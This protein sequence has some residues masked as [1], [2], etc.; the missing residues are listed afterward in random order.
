MTYVI[1]LLMKKYLLI[2]VTIFVFI[3]AIFMGT[4]TFSSA[5]N[6]ITISDITKLDLSGERV[7][8]DNT[9][10]RDIKLEYAFKTATKYVVNVYENVGGVFTLVESGIEKSVENG[11][12]YYE[13]G[14][15]GELRIECIALNQLGTSIGEIS[16]VVK[17]DVTPPTAPV[18][19]SDGVMD[20]AHSAPFSVGY[21]VNGDNL[22]GIDYSRSCYSYRDEEGLIVIPETPIA[23]VYSKAMVNGIDRNGTLTFIIYD[24]AGN[25]ISS[26]KEYNLHHYVESTPPTITVTPQTGYSQ[27]VMVTLSWPQGVS[28]RY[29]KLI[30]N[31]NEHPRTIYD[32]PISI[33]D[34]GKVEIRAYYYKDGIE[35]YVS[36]N[37]T[38]VDNTP[39]VEN[40]IL[41]TIR[42]KVDLTSDTPALLSV[43]PH[44]GKSGIKRVYLKGFGTN[45]HTGNNGVGVYSLDV[46]ER[47]GMNVGIVV[48]DNAGNTTD[49]NY[50]LNGYD[51]EKIVYY[52]NEYKKLNSS[53]FES[54][55]WSELLNSFSRLSNVLSSPTSTGGDIST[56]A[57][58]V[59]GVLSGKNEVKVTLIDIIDGLSNDF[60]ASVP[61]LGTS[62]KKG[63]K[64]NLSVNKIGV[65]ED[66]F[67]EKISVGA[68]IAKFPSYKGYGFN[69]NLTDRDG[70]EVTIYNQM[71]VS[72][73][74]PGTNKLANV[75]QEKDGV[76]VQLSSSIENNVLTFQ[77]ESDGNFYLIVETDP[78]KE[79]G[80][81][82]TIGG[83]FYSLN[84]LLITG[85]IILG[86]MVLAGIITPLIYKL[87]KNKK[88]SRNKFDYFN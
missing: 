17:S 88:S 6:E 45:F 56:Y 68:A 39:P 43:K 86:A 49:Y 15:N 69:L 71:S 40:S 28:N 51:K 23:E 53:D 35:T 10:S 36:K 32:A 37:I 83:K 19:D 42:F 25:F 64:I 34:E 20:T 50:P 16:A 9:Y 62:V 59:D 81:G 8:Y 78:P 18:I 7:P 52:S 3:S 44:D 75:Y 73:T 63:G 55:A 72:L 48:E 70:Q 76:L 79:Q 66:E 27:N 80:A 58:E 82:L 60:T 21:I 5:E 24:K 77:L 46:T 22:S 31:G 38:N 2:L 29:Y 33:V 12:G 67:N 41:E 57:K 4:N 85:G 11:K 14:L 30:V 84:L 13:V 47:I 74:I 65:S 54:V 61:V 26:S 1:L 87:V